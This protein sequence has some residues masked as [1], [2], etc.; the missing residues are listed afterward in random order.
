MRER[1]NKIGAQVNIWSSAGAGT[2]IELTI[3]AKVAYPAHK[4]PTLWRRV[5]GAV[6][7][8]EEARP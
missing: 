3:P 8:T 5:K 4:A 7:R 2:E 6:N 1:A